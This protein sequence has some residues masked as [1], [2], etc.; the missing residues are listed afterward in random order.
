[1]PEPDMTDD[2]PTT[3]SLLTCPECGQC[4]EEDSRFFKNPDGSI[5]PGMT[6]ASVFMGHHVFSAHPE[7]FDQAL[8][9]PADASTAAELAAQL[10]D[11]AWA[12]GID[13]LED[14]HN[15]E[16]VLDIELPGTEEP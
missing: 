14:F 7:K 6:L 5:D 13:L 9:R 11:Y 16:A 12:H 2:T 1:M 10:V 4:V 15:E 3:L 8:D